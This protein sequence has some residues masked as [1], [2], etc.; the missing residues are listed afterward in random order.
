MPE[1]IDPKILA[2]ASH[3]DCTDPEEMI[4]QANR[5]DDTVYNAWG[6]EY[7]V[8]TYSEYNAAIDA[9]CDS[10]IEEF[11]LDKLPE[12]FHAYFD[13]EKYRN[14]MNAGDTDG[15]ISSV[16][17]NVWEERVDGET[18]YIIAHR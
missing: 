10:Y 13:R 3:L 1:P 18:Y 6:N 7:T 11:V 15:L 2:L 14:D 4:E 17:G 5:H 8:Y 9:A 16:D 12:E